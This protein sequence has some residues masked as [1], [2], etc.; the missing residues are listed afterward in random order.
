M[1]DEHREG[2]TMKLAS[3]LGRGTN[4]RRNTLSDNEVVKGEKVMTDE[5][6]VMETD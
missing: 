3:E 1:K 5:G 4:G 2:I 6:E